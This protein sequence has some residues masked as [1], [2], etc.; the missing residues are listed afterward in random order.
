MPKARRAPGKR[1]K[2]SVKAVPPVEE[3]S[4]GDVP[5]FYVNNTQVETSFWDVGLRL[6]VTVSVDKPRNTAQ[7]RDLAHVRMSHQHARVLAGFLTEQ[8]DTY[9]ERYGRIPRRPVQEG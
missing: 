7:V 5:V 4:G 8:L 6:A 1:A 2:V 9:E 3:R